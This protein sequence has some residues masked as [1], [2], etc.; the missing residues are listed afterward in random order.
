MIF[1]KINFVSKGV[2]PSWSELTRILPL[3]AEWIFTSAP[4]PADFHIIFHLKD[5]MVIPNARNRTAFVV[6]EPPEIE[7]L[8]QQFLSQFGVVFGP[9]FDYLIKLPNFKV[10]RGIL[11]WQVF[12]GSGL[13]NMQSDHVDNSFFQNLNR[14]DREIELSIITSN[15]RITRMQDKRLNFVDFLK[16]KIP[17]LEIYGRG[18]RE[19]HDKSDILLRS[20]YHLALENSLHFDYWTEKV[21]DPLLCG[22]QIFYSGDPKIGSTFSNIILLDLSNFE[23]SYQTIVDAI[24][25]DEWGKARNNRK[26]DLENYLHHE[27]I[28]R[29]IQD[30]ILSFEPAQISSNLTYIAKESPFNSEF[31]RYIING[32]KNRLRQIRKQIF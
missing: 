3:Q 20:K 25:S 7:K 14:S 21:I 13:L 1:I 30:W 16:E 17:A 11:P 15:K 22:N 8:S 9:S 27:N 18:Y 23:N 6:G 32:T 10:A 31:S 29:Y 24:S 28:F 19:I 2:N 26:I 12:S 4:I 5:S